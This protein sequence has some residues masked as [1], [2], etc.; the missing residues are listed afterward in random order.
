[1]TAA[2][3]IIRDRRR[4][5]AAPGGFHDRLIR[6][7][8]RAMPAAIGL[9]AAV[10]ILAPLSPRGEI[11]F[12]LDRNR[13]AI[14]SERIRVDKAMYRGQDNEG[15][16]FSLT[17]GSAVQVSPARPVVDMRD[18]VGTLQLTEG[19]ARITAGS[20]A[21]NFNTGQVDVP[22]PVNVT[23]ADGYRMTTNG[24]AI[25][26]KTR[27]VVGS[28]GV[29]GAVPTGTFSANTISADLGER[30][31]TLEG[32]ARLLMTPGKIRMPQ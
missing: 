15:R 5:F 3:D 11:S 17:A 18:L 28:G 4:H 13:V 7:L 10:M 2:A 22:G 8:S 19:P 31:V 24:V 26:L 9:I 25:N 21:Y 6:F 14:T 32:N 27:Q 16:L 30:T 20:G 1:M 29:Q 23:A 12:L